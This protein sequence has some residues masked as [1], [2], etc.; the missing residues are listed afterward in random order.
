MSSEILDFTSTTS[1]EVLLEFF[2]SPDCVYDDQK[3]ALGEH[4]LIIKKTIPEPCQN[5]NGL[6]PPAYVGDSDPSFYAR[7]LH[8]DIF[9][10]SY[11]EN[12][13]QR[14]DSSIVHIVASAL[15]LGKKFTGILACRLDEDQAI[16]FDIQAGT[17][18]GKYFRRPI[19]ITDTLPLNDCKGILVKTISFPS[20]QLS[21]ALQRAI[22]GKN[23]AD[24]LYP[25]V[26]LENPINSYELQ[27]IWPSFPFSS[28]IFNSSSETDELAPIWL[29][30]SIPNLTAEKLTMADLVMQYISSPWPD[31]PMLKISTP[32][33][34][35]HDELA[36][37]LLSEVFQM[38]VDW[39]D[40]FNKLVTSVC[41]FLLNCA[42]DVFNLSHVKPL[43]IFWAHFI[44]TLEEYVQ[45]QLPIVPKADNKDIEAAPLP[46]MRRLIL[47]S[48]CIE[49]DIS[50][51]FSKDPSNDSMF[52]NLI[53][54]S[55]FRLENSSPESISPSP[56]VK[57]ESSN[58]YIYY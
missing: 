29:L 45:N 27:L 51:S 37:S 1:F 57:Q 5:L 58:L 17:V 54:N 21:K 31:E 35:L 41:L 25:W 38:P 20:I 34:F 39:D 28:S 24:R 2:Q 55:R 18:I 48:R 50:K 47:L 7:Y 10:I 33:Q 40:F 15:V 43:S 16:G 52:E 49:F 22:L 14:P 3:F 23:M 4:H 8:A 9:Y 32:H 53:S 19:T 44:R 12:D 42:D 56:M 36:K 11:D 6:G 30:R 13:S 46:M 26:S